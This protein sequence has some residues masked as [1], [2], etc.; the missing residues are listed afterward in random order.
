MRLATK[1]AVRMPSGRW[2]LRKREP[3]TTSAP[4]FTAP[5]S[6]G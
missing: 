5:S 1:L 6:A 3:Y 4:A 2:E